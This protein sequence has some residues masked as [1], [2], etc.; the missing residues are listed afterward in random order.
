MMKIVT[1]IPLCYSFFQ[2]RKVDLKIQLRNHTKERAKNMTWLWGHSN[3][4]QFSQKTK[5]DYGYI[6]YAGPIYNPING[7]GFTFL[8]KNPNFDARLIVLI[9]PIV[10]LNIMQNSGS[11]G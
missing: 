4:N 11:C 9:S 2:E 6:A 3:V 10:D 1:D 5:V 7:R 8:F